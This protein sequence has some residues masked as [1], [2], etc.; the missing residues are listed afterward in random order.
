MGTLKG[1]I[2]HEACLFKPKSLENSFGWVSSKNMATRRFVIDTYIEG[3]VPTPKLTQP[4]K[5]T[6]QQLK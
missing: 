2:Q 3:N 6:S 1:I 4:T 5:L